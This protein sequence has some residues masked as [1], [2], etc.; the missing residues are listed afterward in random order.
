MQSIRTYSFQSLVNETV[1][2]LACGDG[3][4]IAVTTTGVS[5]LTLYNFFW[6][7]NLGYLVDWHFN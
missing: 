2:G 6:I 1:I 5:F 4:T 7:Y 3:Q